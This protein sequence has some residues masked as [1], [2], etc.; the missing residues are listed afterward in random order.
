MDDD[1]V[2]GIADAVAAAGRSD[3]A[4][5]VVGDHS[6]LF[7]RGTVGEGCDRDDLELP[8]V[9]RRLVEAVLDSG[10]PVVLVLLTGRPYAVGWALERCAAV[11]QAFFPGE[12]G[13]TAIAGVVSGRVN[14]SGRLPVSLPRSAGAQPYTYLHPVLGGDGDVTNLATTPAL[15]FGHGLS[16]TSFRH[17]ALEVRAGATS[18]PLVARVRVTNTGGRAGDDVVQLYGRD[19]IGSVTRPVAQLLGYHRLHL[20]AGACAE[21]TFTVPPARLAFTNRAGRRVVEPGELRVWVGASVADHATEVA[22]DLTGGVHSVTPQD[23]RWVMA[24]ATELTAT[25]R[26]T[27]TASAP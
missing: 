21:V 5:V 6:G 18:E 4:V 20:E 3:V 13:G 22:V 23:E 10:T 8:G 2:S 16:Y 11:L 12:E 27:G 25:T 15:P 19:V 17:Q 1:D 24:E 9:Q 7:G 14:P 26:A